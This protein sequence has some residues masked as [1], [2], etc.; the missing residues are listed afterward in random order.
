MKFGSI[1][2]VR[3]YL[4]GEKIVCLECGKEYRKIGG[5]HLKT[6]GMT[7]EEYREKY[8]IPWSYPLASSETSKRYSE[9]RKRYLSDPDNMK[10]LLENRK[11]ADKLKNSVKKRPQLEIAKKFRNEQGLNYPEELAW[12][13]IERIK[14]GRTLT[15]VCEDDDLPGR[16]WMADRLKNNEELKAA[17][18]QAIDSQDFDFQCRSKL[19]GKKFEDQVLKLQSEGY[20][21]SEIS[22]MI[23]TSKSPIYSV[24]RKH[25]LDSNYDP[26]ERWVNQYEFCEIKQ[27][28]SCEE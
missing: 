23:G 16:T 3:E 25:R 5:S 4:K 2:E 26:K 17:Y 6:H 27:S 8:G 15:E 20:T 19:L 28:R 9:F 7:D 21:V 22:E 12:V 13:I 24:F 11:K 18:R 10:E 1:Q 14:E